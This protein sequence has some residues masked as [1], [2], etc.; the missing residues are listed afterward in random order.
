MTRKRGPKGKAQPKAGGAAGSFDELTDALPHDASPNDELEGAISMLGEIDVEQVD[1]LEP[2]IAGEKEEKDEWAEEDREE[3]TFGEDTSDPVRMYLQEM[4]A[5]SL[6]TREQEVEIAKQIESGERE[7]RDEVLALPF[8][9]TYLLELADRIKAGEMSERELLDDESEPEVEETE[10][11]AA[12]ETSTKEPDGA[13]LKQLEKLRK[14]VEDLTLAEEGARQKRAHPRSAKQ[15]EKKVLMAQRRIKKWFD[16]FELS[17]RHT[18]IIV[19]KLKMASRFVAQQQ[20][21]IARM[22][23]KTGKSANEIIKIGGQLKGDDGR[24]A[25][26][27]SRKLRSNT[28]DARRIVD[29]VRSA[30]KNIGEAE[31]EVNMD[32]DALERSLRIVRAGEAKSPGRQ[33]TL[34]RSKPAPRRQHRQALHESRLGIPGPG[35]GRQH[36]AHA[37]RREV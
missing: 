34:D 20:S 5:V 10:G 4:G 36:R 13:I 26:N 28:D 12:E 1:A 19:E 30:K 7:V 25:A 35:P 8:T 23:R 31:R 27:V 18:S 2:S 21:G 14:T 24:T 9:V 37:C 6:L 22:E 16:T 29:E 17:R 3:R 15:A 11:E 33:E 32:Q